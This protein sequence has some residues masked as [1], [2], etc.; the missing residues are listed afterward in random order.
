MV[1]SNLKNVVSYLMLFFPLSNRVALLCVCPT[2]IQCD[3]MHL[4]VARMSLEFRIRNTLLTDR[5]GPKEQAYYFLVLK[6]CVKY[7]YMLKK[8]L[9]YA[10]PSPPFV[11]SDY[12]A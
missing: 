3:F 7:K 8:S 5:V 4:F 9:A 11:N 1:V 10:L 6:M 2:L 12:V